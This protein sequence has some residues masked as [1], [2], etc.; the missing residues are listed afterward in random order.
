MTDSLPAG[1]QIIEAYGN[2]GFTIAGVKSL[3]SILVFVDRVVPWAVARFEDITM[4]AL[5]EAFKEEP[6]VEL[7]LVGCGV[8]QARPSAGLLQGLSE[9]GVI[10]DFMNT[11]AA[12]RT[13]NVLLA[14]DRRVA[15]ALIA[16]D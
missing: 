6:A 4:E 16:V 11:G 13:F 9:A 7:L 2:G 5:C 8:S 15:A 12:C 10:A 3:G 14:E 1:R